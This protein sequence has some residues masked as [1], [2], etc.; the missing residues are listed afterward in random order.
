MHFNATG[1]PTESLALIDRRVLVTPK[2][3]HSVAAAVGHSVV[4]AAVGHSRLA[5][6]FND[7]PLP[8]K[9]FFLI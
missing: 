7:K 3:G 2:S 1:H 9:Q 8:L 4:P 6:D 5:L